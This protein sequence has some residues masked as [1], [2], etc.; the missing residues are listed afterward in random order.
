MGASIE[1]SIVPNVRL[2]LYNLLTSTGSGPTVSADRRLFVSES[3]PPPPPR[4]GRSESVFVQLAY[5]HGIRNGY[6]KLDASP[7][8]IE[9][10]LHH[11]SHERCSIELVSKA[12]LHLIQCVSA[13]HAIPYPVRARSSEKWGHW[14]TRTNRLTR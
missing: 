3:P 7:I 10:L 6:L 8:Q 9:S 4:C 14:I 2:C 11:L 12:F 13:L 5:F 1:I